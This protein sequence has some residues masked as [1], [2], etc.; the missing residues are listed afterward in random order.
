MTAQAL[1]GAASA[2]TETE[3]ELAALLAAAAF[4]TDPA[5]VSYS[6]LLET[7]AGQGRAAGYGSIGD[8]VVGSL[9]FAGP[10]S[11]FSVSETG[12]DRR[13]SLA[14]D[15]SFS[16]AGPELNLTSDV[17]PNL[18]R[19]ISIPGS[20]HAVVMRGTI[21]PSGQNVQAGAHEN[22]VGPV[23]WDFETGTVAE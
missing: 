2:R 3:P 5:E 13:W 10:Q 1:A 20:P 15:G 6:A 19:A 17:S 16:P 23:L 14:P 8:A 4:D 7:V 18:V 12:K 9:H 11:L 22:K 21:P